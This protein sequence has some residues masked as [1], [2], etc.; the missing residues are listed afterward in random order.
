MCVCWN[1]WLLGI[2]LPVVDPI[3]YFWDM[4]AS[5]YYWRERRSNIVW[6]YFRI[7]SSEKAIFEEKELHGFFIKIKELIG[8]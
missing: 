4:A 6:A 5:A 1:M 8:K 2:R 7:Y 3:V